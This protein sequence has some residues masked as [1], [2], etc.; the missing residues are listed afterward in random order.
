M[1]KLGRLNKPGAE[2]NQ[3]HQRNA[4]T[5]GTA[6]HSQQQQQQHRSYHH[7]HH[8][9]YHINGAESR[10]AGEATRDDDN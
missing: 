6:S 9:H 7:N 10:M 1:I 4:Q 3:P 5:D 2:E 8:R